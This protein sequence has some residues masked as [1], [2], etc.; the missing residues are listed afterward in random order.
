VGNSS[1][2]SRRFFIGL[3]D[4]RCEVELREK[5]HPKFEKLWMSNFL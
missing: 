1:I 5:R 3:F 2:Y 4:R